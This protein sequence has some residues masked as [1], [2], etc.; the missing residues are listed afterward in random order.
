MEGDKPT[1]QGDTR[2]GVVASTNGEKVRKDGYSLR[3]PD[4]TVAGRACVQPQ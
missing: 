2:Q 1:M 3:T 4:P